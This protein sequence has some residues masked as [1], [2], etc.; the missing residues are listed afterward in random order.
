MHT[1]NFTAH[2]HTENKSTLTSRFNRSSRAGFIYGGECLCCTAPVDK[3]TH[4]KVKYPHTKTS[5]TSF[6]KSRKKRIPVPNKW[7]TITE[8]STTA[9]TI[10]LETYNPNFDKNNPK[11][12]SKMPT[13]WR[14]THQRLYGNIIPQFEASF[15]S[16]PVPFQ[17]R[18][19]ETYFIHHCN[20]N[21]NNAGIS[22]IKN[23]FRA[24]NHPSASKIKQQERTFSTCHTGK[25]KR[26]PHKQVHR[27]IDRGKIMCT[28]I[29]GP[30][31]L[32]RIRSDLYFEIYMDVGTRY[33][34]FIP[35]LTRAYI[36]QVI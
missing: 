1:K 30:L 25:M 26:S 36:V 7:Q 29:C 22:K 31:N 15:T 34:F 6:G 5:Y 21:I 23:S 20:M 24:F 11:I 33:K 28:D 18:R 14:R 27:H 19:Q 10:P 32:Q 13:H 16:W 3:N 12:H 8:Q 17:E 4:I 9:R 35:I 2:R